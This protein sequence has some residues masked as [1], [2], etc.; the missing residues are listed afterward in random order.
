MPVYD[1]YQA[2]AIGFGGSD[3]VKHVVVSLVVMARHVSLCFNYG[4][5]LA[6]P[7]GLLTGGG[8]QVRFVRLPT[9]ETLDDP[10]VEA[11][12]AAALAQAALPVDAGAPG[13]LVIKSI[14]AK[15]RPRRP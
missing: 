2:L 9:A 1:N 3:R 10:R 12:I 7:D 5:A 13:G 6:N 11:L 4:A 8:N 14:S 15:Q